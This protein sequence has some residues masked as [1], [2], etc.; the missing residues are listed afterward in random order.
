MKYTNLLGENFS[1]DSGKVYSGFFIYISTENG[2][3][4]NTS[5]TKEALFERIIVNNFNY[6]NEK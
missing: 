6:A 4:Q 1:Q 2:D 3:S 5:S